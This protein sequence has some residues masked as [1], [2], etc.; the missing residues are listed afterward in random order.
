MNYH[1]RDAG[2]VQVSPPGHLAYNLASWHFV[3][4]QEAANIARNILAT[5]GRTHDMYSVFDDPGNELFIQFW[6]TALTLVLQARTI[7][8]AALLAVHP[9]ANSAAFR[10]IRQLLN[11]MPLS[12]SRSPFSAG[13]EIGSTVAG[14]YEVPKLVIPTGLPMFW[15]AHVRRFISHLRP[16]YR[17]R[18]PR[19]SKDSGNP[20]L[21]WL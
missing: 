16:K 5:C 18:D 21:P 4:S 1:I 2:H 3:Q 12:E 10:N 19:M 9:S 7:E 6:P 15:L 8:A 11:N 14:P 13:S 20:T 17:V